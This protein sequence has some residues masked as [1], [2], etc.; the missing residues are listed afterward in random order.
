[1]PVWRVGT[2][3]TVVSKSD[4]ELTVGE[5]HSN[6]YFGF[7]TYILNSDFQ[8]RMFHWLSLSPRPV[9]SVQGKKK[10]S[11]ALRLT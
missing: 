6:I 9:C 5:T 4:Q 1:M 8:E 11:L 3:T 2:K 10:K 7:G